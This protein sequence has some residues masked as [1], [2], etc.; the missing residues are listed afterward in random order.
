MPISLYYLE[1]QNCPDLSLCGEVILLLIMWIILFSSNLCICVCVYMSMHLLAGVSCCLQ[2]SK[3]HEFVFLPVTVY[4]SVLP[5]WSATLVF[6]LLHLS[7]KPKATERSDKIHR[8]PS[9]WPG[10]TVYVFFPK[11]Q[12]HCS[13]I[14]GPI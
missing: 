10:F 14:Q 13:K 5:V 6:A 12:I 3:S 4:S 8:D 1:S 9:K 2:S 7:Q 11:F